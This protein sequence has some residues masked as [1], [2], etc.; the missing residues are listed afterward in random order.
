MG[1]VKLNIGAGMSRIPGFVNIDISKEA[2]VTLDLSCDALPFDTDSVDL[3]FSYHTL[4]HVDN[5]LFALGEIHRVLRHE[6]R[7]LIGLPYVLTEYH[8]VNPY[9]VHNFNERFFEFFDPTKIK[10]SAVEANPV[11]FRSIFNRYHYMGGFRYVPQPFRSWCRRHLFNVV[12]KIDIGLLA[13]KDPTK[14]IC[15]DVRT[16]RRLEREFRACLDARVTH[17]GKRLSRKNRRAGLLRR[18][19]RRY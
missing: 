15:V 19:E 6:G 11:L 14:P 9:H 12:W 17:G 8:V 7:L 18:L 3:I 4:E 5:L 2:D 10:G 13:I 16:R 1:E